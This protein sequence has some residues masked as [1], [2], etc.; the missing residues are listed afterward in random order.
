MK[1]LY[2]IEDLGPGGKERQLTELL[3]RVCH[4]NEIKCDLLVLSNE[5]HYKEILELDIS[6]HHL[7]RKSK[8]DIRIF[9]KLYKLCR[10]LKPDII[11]TWGTMTTVYAAPIAKLL[12]IRLINGMVRSAAPRRSFLDFYYLAAFL[13]F[14]VSDAIVSNSN[15]GLE[16]FKAPSRKGVRIFNGF[17]MQRA[18][19][20]REPLSMKEELS[21]NTGKVVGMVAAVSERKDYDTYLEAAKKILKK[22]NDTLFLS[23]GGGENLEEYRKTVEGEWGNKIRFLGVRSDVESLVNIFDVGVL[24]TNT[25][26]HNEGIPNAVMEYMALGK[27]VVATDSGGTKELVQHNVTGLIVPPGDP[28]LLADSIMRLLDDP[29]L[30]KKMGQAGRERIEQ[31]FSK[32][33]MATTFLKL[34]SKFK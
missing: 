31:V 18:L 25:R 23:A 3:Q 4:Q 24:T 8:K 9:F 33:K 32:E 21:I 10:Q 34:Y 7:I 22:R 11:H 15:A 28:E 26:V 5:I 2:F 30:A 27:P 17:D 16:A 1:I 12:N 29:L 6:V 14:P 20:V 19:S 13:T